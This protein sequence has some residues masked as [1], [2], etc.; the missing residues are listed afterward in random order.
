VKTARNFAILA[1]VAAAFAF[2]PGG[3]STVSVILTLLT[4]AFLSVIAFAGYRLYREHRFTLESLEQ[5]LRLILYASIGLAFLAFAAYPRLVPG[6]GI[7]V[8]IGLL[9]IASF[10]AYWVFTQSRKYD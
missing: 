2:L 7:L 1:L 9:A 3:S 8:F 10:G 4:I 6:P 5:H